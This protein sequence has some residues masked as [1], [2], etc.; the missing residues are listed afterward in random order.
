M[1]A[2]DIDELRQLAADARE[3]IWEQAKAYNREP[4]I[5]LHWTAGHYGQYYLNDYHVAIDKDGIIYVD[6]PLDDVLA[7]TYRRNSGAVGI[8]LACCVGATSADLGSEPPTARQIEAMAQAIVAVADG[9]WLTIDRDHVL[10]HG[11]AADNI[12]GIY[13]HEEYGPLTTVERW[14]LQY[15]GTDESPYYIKDY[16]DPRTGGNVLRGKANWYRNEWAK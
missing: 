4:K 3:S 13:P 12:D 8:T 2:V 15:L 14:D 9:L 5:Y 6:A 10:T 16:D 1:R 11:E 7:H